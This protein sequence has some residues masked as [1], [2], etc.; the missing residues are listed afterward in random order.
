MEAGVS[1]G[2]HG[3]RE[4]YVADLFSGW[5]DLHSGEA[6]SMIDGVTV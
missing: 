3:V 6:V 5:R 1:L 2:I 4:G